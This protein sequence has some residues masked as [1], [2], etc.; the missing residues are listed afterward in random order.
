[1]KKQALFFF[2][3]QNVKKIKMSSAAILFGTLSVKLLSITVFLLFISED[4]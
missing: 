1:M 2:E 4:D 3:R